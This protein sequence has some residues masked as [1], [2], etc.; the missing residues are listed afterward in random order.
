ME[1]ILIDK[2]DPMV[3]ITEFLNDAKKV[4]NN[5]HKSYHYCAL[6][7]NYQSVHN[8]EREFFEVTDL[9][10]NEGWSLLIS[11]T[12]LSNTLIDNVYEIVVNLKYSYKYSY[13][14][15]SYF[16][17]RE[18]SENSISID[19]FDTAYAAFKGLR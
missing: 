14:S 8:I 11:T 18:K 12:F 2:K 13:V 3:D 4:R 17:V 7:S 1:I 10:R 19:F 6:L 16:V 9:T 5:K 15:K